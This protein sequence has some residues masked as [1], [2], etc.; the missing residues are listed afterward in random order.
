MRLNKVY[1]LAPNE[2]WICD[3]IVNEWNKGNPDI[4]VFHPKDADVVWLYS[5]WCWEGLARNGMLVGKKIITTIHHIVP[6]KFDYLAQ[7]EFK[8]RDAITN[9]YHVYNN[10]TREF[11]LQYTKKP[12][13]VI[14]YW[15]NKDTWHVTGTKTE[16]RLKYGLPAD[17]FIIGSM[18]RDT[19]GAGIE[20]GVY[21]PKLEKG[22][23]LLA[24]YIEHVQ[25]TKDCHVVLGGWRRQYIIQRLQA[26]GIPYTY[27]E[28]PKL[29]VI[30]DLYQTLDLYPVTARYEGGPQSLI[31]CG[32]LNVPV[33]SR[34]VGIAEQVLPT[35]AIDDDVT[36][37][38]P[39]VPDVSGWHL[40]DAFAEYRSLIQS[41]TV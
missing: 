6:E 16:L 26:A 3:R 39:A 20:R 1:V 32:L 9:V 36:K 31:E 33:V 30:N 14:K 5:D 17:K 4:S 18:Q 29:S 21:L 2:D 12:I 7:D 35:S 41:I 24:D 40:P 25:R 23:D 13:V 34:H 38:V 37:C 19:E 22:P 8:R 10:H 11:I 27:F 28:R 15:A